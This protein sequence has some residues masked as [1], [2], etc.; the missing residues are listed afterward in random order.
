MIEQVVPSGVAS[1][2]TFADPAGY[3]A[4]G[5]EEAIIA[6][7]VDKRRREF[8]TARDCARGR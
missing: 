7:A 4:D 6:R 5:G 1:V 3:R 2:E 8:I